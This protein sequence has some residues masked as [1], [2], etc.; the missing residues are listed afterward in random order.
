[1]FLVLVVE[2]D[3]GIRGMLETL[4]GAQ[5]YRVV[6]AE[7]AARGVI[8]AR[9]HRP[10]LIIVDLGLPD[11]D[12]LSLIRDIRR[13]AATP[14]LVLSARTAEADK[15]AALDAGADDYV[16]KPFSTPELMARVRAALRRR[17]S[18]GERLPSLCFGPVRVDLA[19]R[20]A[21]G[22]AGPLHLTPLEYRV[23]DC[24]ARHA[25]MIVTQAELLREAWG[26]ERAGDS[27]G[28]RTYVKMLRQKL[29][30]DP[31]RPQY[32]ITEPGVGY[33]LLPVDEDPGPS[34]P[35]G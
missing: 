12:G 3:A 10:D 1:M 29:E 21:H 31:R 17:I 28:L 14:I 7:N 35:R 30:P 15:I 33:R 2:D 19:A 23:L 24:L 27:R 34:E 25:G 4:L 20:T 13:F 8:E 18:S 5:H 11:R 22:P 26:A 9:N 16:S 32:L 6:A